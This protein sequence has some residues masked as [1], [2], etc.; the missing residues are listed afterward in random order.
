M[1]SSNAKYAASAVHDDRQSQRTTSRTCAVSCVIA[2]LLVAFPVPAFAKAD[3]DRS[4]TGLAA[5]NDNGLEFSFDGF[6][7][8][9]D[10]IE[11]S[12]DG[13]TMFGHIPVANTDGFDAHVPHVKLRP[14]G[15]LLPT[16]G[17]YGRFSL[18]YRMKVK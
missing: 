10:S 1:Q 3:L 11:F 6:S 18:R 17:N 8:H 9:K 12:S 15:A 16:I 7:S 13:S 5:F 14:R 4:G 2:C